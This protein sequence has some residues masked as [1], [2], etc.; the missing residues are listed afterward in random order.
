MSDRTDSTNPGSSTWAD[1]PLAAKSRRE[2]LKKGA[3]VTPTLLVLGTLATL[4]DATAQSTCNGFPC[5]PEGSP[6]QRKRKP[7]G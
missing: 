4:N 5:G 2:L 1:P 6:P 7:P 3:Y